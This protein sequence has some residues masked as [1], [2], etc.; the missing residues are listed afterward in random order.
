ME[1]RGF[2]SENSQTSSPNAAFQAGE[3]GVLPENGQ[4]SSPNA[5]PVLK[6]SHRKGAVVVHS[7][8]QLHMHDVIFHIIFGSDIYGTL[9]FVRASAVRLHSITRCQFLVSMMNCI[10]GQMQQLNPSDQHALHGP[11]TVR[12][13]FFLF[14]NV[15]MVL[16][17]YVCNPCD[18][19]AFATAMNIKYKGGGSNI[20]A[21]QL[22][23]LQRMHAWSMVGTRPMHDAKARRFFTTLHDKI[24]CEWLQDERLHPSDLMH[25]VKEEYLVC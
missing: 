2:L 14:L 23:I 5:A 12:A 18:K 1:E 17:E 9:E 10:T 19:K 20:S 4:T 22:K 15:D 11:D 25:M 24:V 3:R 8:A 7:S 21:E 6:S 16:K 13:L